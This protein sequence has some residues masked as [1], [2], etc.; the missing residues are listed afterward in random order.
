M[1]CYVRLDFGLGEFFI[2]TTPLDI[3]QSQFVKR[4]VK[5]KLGFDSFETTEKITCQIGKLFE[6]LYM[7]RMETLK[8]F[9]VPFLKL[10]FLINYRYLSLVQ[11]NIL[12][13][14][15]VSLTL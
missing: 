11:F 1:W 10:S 15:K 6:M 14:D 3:Q 2:K 8:K 9:N 13:S 7:I 4:N 12:V 5:Q